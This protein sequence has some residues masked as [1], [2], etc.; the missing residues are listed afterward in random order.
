M[1][2]LTSITGTKTWKDAD[3]R[4]WKTSESITVNLFADGTKP[5]ARV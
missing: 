4:G 2:R 3:N 5:R 1:L